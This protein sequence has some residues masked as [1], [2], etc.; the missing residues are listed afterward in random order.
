MRDV[1]LRVR[2][3]DLER[4]VDALVRDARAAVVRRSRV[5]KQAVVLVDGI[6]FDIETTIGPPY[7]S[8]LD[9]ASMLA[10][11]RRS[12]APLGFSHWQP[13]LIDHVL[14]LVTN[15]YKD[16][17]VEASRWSVDDLLRIVQLPAFRSGELVTRAVETRTTTMLYVVAQSLAARDPTGTWAQVASVVVPKRG[18]RAAAIL[19]GS[20]SESSPLSRRLRFR[21]GADGYLDS[22]CA[23][24]AGGL[25]ELERRATGLRP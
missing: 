7:L 22:A 23:V 24:I 9:V 4:A 2:P 10:R 12:V 18:R 19:R 16:H 17:V 3:E 25:F 14:L 11:A 15:L 20:T 8:R 21:A 5:Y 13:E 6:E 1:D